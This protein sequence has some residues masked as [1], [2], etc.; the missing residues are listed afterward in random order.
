MRTVMRIKASISIHLFV[1]SLSLPPHTR[2]CVPLYVC[3][4]VL[5]VVCIMYVCYVYECVLWVHVSSVCVVFYVY[6]YDVCD[7]F[8]NIR[9]VLYVYCVLWCT[10]V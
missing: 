2:M 5:C 10:G 4:Y 3:V 7:A 8:E 1:F 9:F 6:M